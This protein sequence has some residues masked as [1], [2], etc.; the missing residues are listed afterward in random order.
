[1]A[2]WEEISRDALAASQELLTKGRIRSAISRAYYA[3]YSAITARIRHGPGAPS[4][5]FQN[6]SHDQAGKLLLILATMPLSQRRDLAAALRRLRKGR[7]DADYRPGRTLNR[8]DAIKLIRD[9]LRVVK[10]LGVSNG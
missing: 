5:R 7:E 10:G 3:A 9:S 1:M 8:D 6:P 2:T 4:G